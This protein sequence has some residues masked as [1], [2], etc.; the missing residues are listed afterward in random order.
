MT[1]TGRRPLLAH[2]RDSPG[3]AVRAGWGALLLLRPDTGIDVLEGRGDTSE[4]ARVVIRI[5]GARHLIELGLELRHGPAWR[6]A[7]GVVDAIHSAT[8]MGFSALDH[9]WRR[10]AVADA[11][12]A[13]GFA[14]VGLAAH[15]RQP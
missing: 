3:L 11:L 10:A 13:G 12:V 9:R 15:D 7:G 6:R 4:P 8:A 1:R 2:L 14:V 5:L